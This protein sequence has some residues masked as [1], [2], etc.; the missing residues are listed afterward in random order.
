[1][2][3]TRAPY[4]RRSRIFSAVI[5]R[6]EYEYR[7][8]AAHRGD[9]RSA[10]PTPVLPLVASTIVPP[11]FSRP[12]FSASSIM[13]EPI[14]SLDGPARVEELE[15][16]EDAIGDPVSDPMERDSA[17]CCQ[18]RSRTEVGPESVVATGVAKGVTA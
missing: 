16:G 18:T 14:R 8:V 1:M 6:E 7:A 9:V 5:C 11:G 17:G 12:F 2:T 4:E 3:T 10:R 15:F 13:T